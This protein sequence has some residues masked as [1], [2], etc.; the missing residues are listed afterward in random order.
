M[1]NRTLSDLPVTTVPAGADILHNR[2]GTTDKSIT[3][4]LLSEYVMNDSDYSPVVTTVATTTHTI[5]TTIRKQIIICTI[6]SGCTLTFPGSYGDGHE[7][8]IINDSSSTANVTGLPNSE[9]L[10]PGEEIVFFWDGSAF[11][12]RTF[13]NQVNLGTAAPTITPGFIGQ[14]FV[15]YTND[16]LYFA[17]GTGSSADWINSRNTAWSVETKTADYTLTTA[18]LNKMIIANPN[19]VSQYGILEIELPLGSATIVGRP[20]KVKHGANQGLIKIVVNSGGSDKIIYRGLELDYLLLYAPGDK[21][22]LVWDGTSFDCHGS[23][24]MIISWENWSDQ[25]ARLL[26]NRITYDNG[27]GGSTKSVDWTGMVITEATSGYTAVVVEDT[28]GA[29]TTGELYVYELS[30]GFTFWTN[31][32][33]LTASNSETIDVN[34][35]SGSTLDQNY[36]LY[37]E[38]GVNCLYFTVKMVYNTSAS[39]TNAWEIA[40]N[41][42]QSDKGTWIYN[43]SNNTI[44][45]QTGSTGVGYLSTP[46]G[47]NSTI[48][49]TNAYLYRALYFSN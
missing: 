20:Y 37:H 45:I 1:A 4:T 28:G 27:S 15:D 48:T 44:I 5:S 33:I 6:S 35:A 26:G 32:R 3:M 40:L 34:E 23:T 38:F 12:K 41:T 47:G 16:Q 42:D 17:T 43:V 7:I 24:T 11:T 22:E 13:I 36:N 14:N 8:I 10:Y 29:S 30:S 2:Q 49:G 19:T 31:N 46:A 25:T 39:F 21:W 18:D 9:T